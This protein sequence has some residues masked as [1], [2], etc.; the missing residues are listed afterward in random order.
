MN[1]EIPEIYLKNKKIK[2]ENMDEIDIILCLNKQT[3]KPKQTKK[4]KKLFF[5]CIKN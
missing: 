4:K 1:T 3:K 2:R 5:L